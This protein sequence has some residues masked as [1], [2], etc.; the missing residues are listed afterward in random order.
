MKTENPPNLKVTANQVETEIRIFPK[1]EIY[2]KLITA[3]KEKR[4]LPPEGWCASQLDEEVWKATR[5]YEP[6]A[7]LRQKDA[8][9][10]SLFYLVDFALRM[11]ER[12]NLT[13]T[14]ERVKEMC[15]ELAA[16]IET[17]TS[18]PDEIISKHGKLKT[19]LKAILSVQTCLIYTEETERYIAQEDEAKRLRRAAQNKNNLSTASKPHQE[20]WQSALAKNIFQKAQGKLPEKAS[21]QPTLF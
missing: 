7:F 15:E 2:K 14:N 9:E 20:K 8:L 5:E 6:D 1:N 16:E 4:P 12:V 13:E 10:T 21:D 11:P 3:L 17:I 19:W 18:A